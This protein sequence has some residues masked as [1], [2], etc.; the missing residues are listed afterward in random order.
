[1]NPFKA[2]YLP[3]GV[4]TFHKESIDDQFNKSKSLLQSLSDAVE[5]PDKPLLTI[6]DLMAFIEGK[7]CDLIILQN[8]AFA[9]SEYASEILR[10]IDGDVLLWT[11]QEPVID[12]GRLRLNSLTGAYSAGNLMHHVGKE[13]FEYIWGSP[14]DQ[15]VIKKLKSV[16]AA[17][18]LKR[19]FKTMTLAS[20]GHTPQGFGFGRGIDAEIGRYFGMKHMAV[21]VRELMD[22]AKKYTLEECQAEI[23]ESKVKLLG[24]SNT[25]DDNRV[26]FI[27]LYKSYSDFIKENNIAAISS[28][29]WPDFFVDFGTPVCA[30]LGM[31][32]DNQIAA[33]CEADAYGALSMLIGMRLSGESVFFGDPVSLDQEE[34]TITFWHCGTAACSLAHPRQGAQI[35]VHPNRKIGPTMEFGCKPSSQ[36][37]VFR[38]GR[39]P[40]GGIRFFIS[41]GEILDKPQQFLGTSLVFKTKRPSID[42][43]SNSVQ[44]GWE[45]H[46]I[47][48]YKDIKE[49][50]MTLGKYL[51]AE[52]CLYE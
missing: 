16:L 50:L 44:D 28:R 19:E 37:T 23:E 4:P 26:D 47:V 30:V 17:A 51:K 34:S 40:D 14:E 8:N 49:E 3:I 21:E 15:R 13:N 11:L 10:A 46:F 20:I 36:A 38:V 25:P 33:S 31:L 1:M 7:S 5:C 35:G 22:R 9:N 18:Q 6:P 2:L 41:T 45:P 24:L 32:N 39:K 48:A 52:I 29:C 43:V 42:I 27:R 12:G